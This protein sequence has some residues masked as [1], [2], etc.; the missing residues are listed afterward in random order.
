[1]SAWL[2]WSVTSFVDPLPVADVYVTSFCLDKLIATASPMH[3]IEARS[4]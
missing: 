4:V 3:I 2:P 1:M